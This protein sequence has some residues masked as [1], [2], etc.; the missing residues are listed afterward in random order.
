VEH[1]IPSVSVRFGVAQFRNVCGKAWRQSGAGPML[2]HAAKPY[3]SRARGPS[4]NL[5]RSRSRAVPSGYSV[6]DDR[7]SIRG[8]IDTDGTVRVD[9]R[10]EG[11]V[12]R[13]G[14]LIVGA[15][16]VVGGD[17]EAREVVV[18]GTVEGNVHASV[19][20]EIESGAVVHGEIRAN[21]MLLREGGAVHGQVSIGTAPPSAVATPSGDRRLELASTPSASLG[22]G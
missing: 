1:V 14:M 6:I 19:R 13:A 2:V 4:M 10:I 16:G 7:L 3:E 21:A 11:T 8:E 17:I 18:A 9:G 12:H 22:R 15:G 5:F 20:V